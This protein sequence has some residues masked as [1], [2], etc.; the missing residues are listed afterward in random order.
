[1]GWGKGRVAGSGRGLGTAQPPS[2]G[3]AADAVRRALSMEKPPPALATPA[4]RPASATCS[5]A[6]RRATA[7][8]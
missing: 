1:V 6:A 3:C 4:D 7:C 5:A 8:P 2:R